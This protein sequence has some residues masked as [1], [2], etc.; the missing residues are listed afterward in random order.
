MLTETMIRDAE[1]IKVQLTDAVRDLN[2][3]MERE[4]Q[5]RRAY[6]DAKQFYADAEAE[7]RFEAI[8]TVEGKNAEQRAA[9]VD[10]ALIRERTTGR[11]AAVWGRMVE[12]QYEADSAKLAF[13][14]MTRRYRAIESAADL[15]A[16]ML[17]SLSR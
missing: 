8:H 16:A 3:A 4:S 5:S 9:G 15:T 2:L 13:D 1:S 6:A 17:K 10:L 12:A 14:Q 7:V 11:L